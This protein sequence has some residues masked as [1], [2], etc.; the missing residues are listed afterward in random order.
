[1]VVP[2]SIGEERYVVFDVSA[3][4]KGDRHYFNESDAERH[5]RQ[6]AASAITQS[7]EGS[8]ASGA[9]VGQ[10]AAQTVGAASGG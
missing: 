6:K 5:A 10:Q 7:P 3:K 2:T 4:R 8:G 1:L 9:K